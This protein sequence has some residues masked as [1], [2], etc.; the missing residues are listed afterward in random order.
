[1]TQ[2][3]VSARTE[4]RIRTW[5]SWER[6]ETEP[7]TGAVRMLLESWVREGDPGVVRVPVEGRVKAGDADVQF[8]VHLGD[9]GA[10]SG[11]EPLYAVEVQG[12]S[13][14]PEIK[15]GD[16]LLCRRVTADDEVVPGDI[17]VADVGT[18]EYVVKRL[19][20]R[21]GLRVLE[22]LKEGMRAIEGPF[23]LHGKV[24]EIRRPLEKRRRRR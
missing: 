5:G 9:I 16:R 11:D 22:S 7:P 21:Q 1:M 23:R 18:E 17:V 10:L 14:A 4:T 12:D 3:E 2:E 19:G 6:G 20:R 24:I 8:G 13:M 15:S